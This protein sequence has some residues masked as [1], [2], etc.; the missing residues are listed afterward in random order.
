M[1]KEDVK[2]DCSYFKGHIPCNPN[3][4]YNVQC[5]TC[6]HYIQQQSNIIHLATQELLLK[7]I[8]NICNF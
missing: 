6:S 4:Q 5:D 8:Y 7:E 1:R 3:K 2:Y